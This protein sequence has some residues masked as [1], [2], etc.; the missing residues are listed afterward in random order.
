MIRAAIVGLLVIVLLSVGV[1]SIQ[2]GAWT[3]GYMTGLLTAGGDASAVAPLLAYGHGFSPAH[4]G[5][6]FFGAIF[7]LGFF[8]IFFAMMAKFFGF[9][10]WRMNGGRHGGWGKHWHE[11][12]GHHGGHNGPQSD[13]A[14]EDTKPDEST[15]DTPSRG[16]VRQASYNGD[17]VINV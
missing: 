15:Q 3:Q 6:S 7:K 9:W 1:S 8:F 13:Q 16:D 17:S 11:R 5:F 2:Q 10:M 4:A 12:H 14:Q